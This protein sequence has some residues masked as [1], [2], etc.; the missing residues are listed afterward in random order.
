MEK[1]DILAAELQ[2]KEGAE[3]QLN[4]R[5]GAIEEYK[6]NSQ[7]P[8]DLQHAELEQRQKKR[9]HD[10][11]RE[12]KNLESMKDVAANLKERASKFRTDYEDEK[13]KT[14]GRVGLET[15]AVEKR[16]WR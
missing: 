15:E 8:L 16:A 12:A 7:R 11:A 3:K 1:D 13:K 4:K 5:R 14:E 2:E 10:E 6:L 9:K